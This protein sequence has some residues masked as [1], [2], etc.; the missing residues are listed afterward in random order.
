MGNK[1]PVQKIVCLYLSIVRAMEFPFQQGPNTC[2]NIRK[3]GCGLRGCRQRRHSPRAAMMYYG[4]D[5]WQ[6][7]CVAVTRFGGRVKR[8]FFLLEIKAVPSK[9]LGAMGFLR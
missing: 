1:K 8:T 9:K 4:K 2:E 7:D 6:M 3:S 5:H